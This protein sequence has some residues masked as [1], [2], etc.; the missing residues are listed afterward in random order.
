[1][2]TQ[3]SIVIFKKAKAKQNQI[4]VSPMEVAISTDTYS[5]N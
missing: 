1:M 2:K 5:E 3:E 4:H